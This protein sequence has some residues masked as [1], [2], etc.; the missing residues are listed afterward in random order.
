[1]VGK[2][3]ISHGDGFSPIERDESVTCRTP[4]PKKDFGHVEVVRPI[5]ELQMELISS[6]TKNLSNLS[7]SQKREE[8][9]VKKMILASLQETMKQYR[10]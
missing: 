9:K 4:E 6:K 5:L 8:V 2:I 7:L 10:Y 3:F 1:G